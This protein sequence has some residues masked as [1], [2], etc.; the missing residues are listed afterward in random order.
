MLTVREQLN[1]NAA[2]RLPRHFSE[3]NR[4]TWL[5]FIIDM[6]GLT[7]CKH[8]LIGDAEVR[9]ISGGQRKRV[10]IGME[11]VADPALL[12]LDEPTS[13]LDSSAAAEVMEA[14]KKAASFGM[15]VC[16]VIHQPRWGVF[17]SLYVS[18]PLSLSLSLHASTLFAKRLTQLRGLPSS[19]LNTVL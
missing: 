2:L 15:T 14:L 18:T 16:A 9:G 19:A 10:N 8:T 11:L 6:L 7:D 17:Q 13:G 5:D 4:R 12:F 1:F 3:E